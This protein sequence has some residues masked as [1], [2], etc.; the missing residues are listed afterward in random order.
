MIYMVIRVVIMS[1][2]SQGKGEKDSQVTMDTEK[3]KKNNYYSWGR[4]QICAVH[5]NK[6]WIRV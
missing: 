3:S 2:L 6:T 5:W 4:T 1:G